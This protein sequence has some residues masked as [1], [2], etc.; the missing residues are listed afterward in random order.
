MVSLYQHQISE[1]EQESDIMAVPPPGSWDRVSFL[2]PQ[3]LRA[4]ISEF[5]FQNYIQ[6]RGEAM[7]RLIRSGLLYEQD[8]GNYHTV[9]SVPTSEEEEGV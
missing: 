3:R 8:R 2:I 4:H 5:Q 1:D 7:R 6:G 9:G